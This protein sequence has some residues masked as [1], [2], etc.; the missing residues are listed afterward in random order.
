MQHVI[1]KALHDAVQCQE[2]RTPLAPPHSASPQQL[3]WD[4]DF[5]QLPR[6]H[7]HQ[8]GAGNHYQIE[9]QPE[10]KEQ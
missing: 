6:R 7:L 2:V 1:V 10:N 8:Q 5:E 4:Y 3:D 9:Q